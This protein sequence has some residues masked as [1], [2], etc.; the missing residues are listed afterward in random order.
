M[1]HIIT[2]WSHIFIATPKWINITK[3]Q[4][5]LELKHNAVDNA[6]YVP[7]AIL[8]HTVFMPMLPELMNTDSTKHQHSVLTFFLETTP[9]PVTLSWL[10]S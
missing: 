6:M 2:S 3:R 7:A 1:V 8:F 4:Q 5:K 9:T 10:I